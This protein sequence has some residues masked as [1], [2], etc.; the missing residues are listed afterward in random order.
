METYIEASYE[1][2]KER[3][4]VGEAGEKNMALPDFLLHPEELCTDFLK[5]T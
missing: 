2:S 5:F 3:P 1:K 4:S